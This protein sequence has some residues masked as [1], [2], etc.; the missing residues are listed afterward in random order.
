M[1]THSQLHSFPKILAFGKVQ[2]RTRNARHSLPLDYG[3]FPSFLRGHL[4]GGSGRWG[5]LPRAR[6]FWRPRGAARTTQSCAGA[7]GAPEGAARD[8]GA[9]PRGPSG[10]VP[11]AGPAAAAT[12]ADQ[13]ALPPRPAPPPPPAWSLRRGARGLGPPPPRSQLGPRLAPRCPPSR[14][15]GHSPRGRAAAAPVAAAAGPA[16]RGLGSGSGPGQ[17]A[18]GAERAGGRRTRRRRRDDSAAAAGIQRAQS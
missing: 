6:T 9:G 7:H 17:Q 2:T 10:G 14:A 16:W 3:S 5:G 13:E 11:S 1:P 18:R 8:S 12:P 4:W 15:P